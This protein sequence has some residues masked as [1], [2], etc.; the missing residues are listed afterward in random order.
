MFISQT[1]I[2]QCISLGGYK[3]LIFVRI[4]YLVPHLKTTNVAVHS[5]Y[6]ESMSPTA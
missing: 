1:F 6:K 4:C 2:F 3:Q 5:R